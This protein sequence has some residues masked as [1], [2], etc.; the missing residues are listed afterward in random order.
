[1]CLVNAQ[2][3]IEH[4]KD[5]MYAYLQDMRQYMPQE[6][7]AFISYVEKNTQLRDFAKKIWQ[8]SRLFARCIT[9]ALSKS[10]T[11]VMCIWGMRKTI[12]KQDEENAFTVEVL[13][14]SKSSN[15]GKN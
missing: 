10:A 15:T 4:K 6:A 8:K 11:F 14:P 2:F 5:E 12:H 9:L 7:R 1:M 13:T 3:G